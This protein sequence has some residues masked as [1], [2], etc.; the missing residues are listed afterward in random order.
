MFFKRRKK[1]FFLSEKEIKWNLLWD[2][3]ADGTLEYNYYVLCDYHAGVNG[4]GHYGF[5]DNNSENLPQ[6]VTALKSLLPDEFFAEFYKAYEA[7][8]NDD[9]TDSVCDAADDYFYENEQTI[10]DILQSYADSLE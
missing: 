9:D 7:Y 5:F 4:E 3:Y 10:I 8:V 1:K 2:K 6:Y